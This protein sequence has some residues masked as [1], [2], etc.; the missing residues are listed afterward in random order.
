[1]AENCQSAFAITSCYIVIYITCCKVTAGT[2]LGWLGVNILSWRG[3]RREF[4][5]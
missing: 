3:K 5:K 4:K 2:R 1:M